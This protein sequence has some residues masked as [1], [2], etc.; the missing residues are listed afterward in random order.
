LSYRTPGVAAGGG[1]ATVRTESPSATDDVPQRG[2]NRVRVGST[3]SDGRRPLWRPWFSTVV[4]LV[5]AGVFAAAAIAKI[6][7]VEGMVRAVR[8]YQIL[9]EGAVRPVA[10]ALPYLELAVAL[11]LLLG[12]GTRL[13][14]GLAAVLLVLFIAAVASAGLRGL[15]IDCGCFGGGGV[16]TQTHYLREIGRDSVFLL[17]AGWLA[18]FPGSRLALDN[19]IDGEDI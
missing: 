10:Y 19:L 9:P 14:A 3:G 16:V 18:V 5:L 13:V 12:L 4:R 15:R 2:G 7:S 8:A 6:G 1:R 11:L 17:L